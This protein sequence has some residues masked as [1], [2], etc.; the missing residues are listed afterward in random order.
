MNE[1]AL[2]K[3]LEQVRDGEISLDRA[4]ESLRS[5]PYDDL[6]YARVDTQRELRCG[7]PEVIFCAGKRPEHIEAIARSILKGSDVLLA[8]RADRAAF[9]AIRAA[10][11]DA[12]YHELARCVT[13][14]RQTQEADGARARANILIVCAGTS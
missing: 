13:V 5:F 14:R 11:P 7:F 10:S 12:E 6:P 4:F 9:E 8:T 3:L 2:R 1:S